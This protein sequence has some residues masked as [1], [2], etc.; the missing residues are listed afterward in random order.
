[1][2]KD[3][4]TL[5]DYKPKPMLVTEAHIPEKARYPVVDAHNHLFGD[6]DPAE[7]IDV[8]DETGVRVFI[9]LTGNTEFKFVEKGYTAR[10]RPIDYYLERYVWKH[11]GR[12][13]CFTMSLFAHLQQETLVTDNKFTE[14][15]VRELEQDVGKGACGLKV[16]KELGLFFKDNEGRFIKV[17]D[18]R[19]SPIWEAA[20]ELGIPVL[21]HTSDPAAFFLPIDRFNEHYLTLQQA[22]DWSFFG[23]YYSKA[24]LLSQR[25]RM[26]ARHPRTTFICAH[27]AN[28]PEDL[29]YVSD[30][31]DSHP[32]ACIDFSARIDELGRQPYTARDFMIR[33][34]DR[35]LFGTDMPAHNDVY[36]AYFRFLETR[37][38]H[39]EYPDYVGRFG[40]SRWKIYGL[41]LPDE[42]LE[43]IYHRN[44]L[45]IIPGLSIG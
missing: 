17:D 23:S 31:L 2:Y 44:A 8:M 15:A 42:V 41:H 20:G 40:F 14:R 6:V 37:D 34:Q 12:F 29:G 10:P 1:M 24:E 43:K 7:M 39:F 32:N 30:F 9:N 21:I 36:R 33:Y 28:F 26:I 27:V 38:E 18:E 3:D 35:I 19:L 13:A 45:R 11:P 4:L 22:P 5:K 25:D 16:T